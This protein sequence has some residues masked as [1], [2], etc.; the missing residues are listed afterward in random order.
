VLFIRPLLGCPSSFLLLLHP[1]ELQVL[2]I[3]MQRPNF[4]KVEKVL[5]LVEDLNPKTTIFFDPDSKSLQ[6]F[7]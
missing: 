3:D 6:F 4:L 7:D 1:R 2:T 5:C